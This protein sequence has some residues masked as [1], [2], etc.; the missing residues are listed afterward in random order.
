MGSRCR[1]GGRS[2]GHPPAHAEALGATRGA[3]HEES[4][5]Q[6]IDMR[7]PNGN[8]FRVFAPRST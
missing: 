6:W 2:R 8:R 5:V 1:C 3:E 7:D 4:G